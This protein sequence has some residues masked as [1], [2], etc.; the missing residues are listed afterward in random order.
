MTK[1]KTK[2]KALKTI[3]T[4]LLDRS[5]SMEA[6]K[7]DTIGAFNGYLETLRD[8]DVD[9]DFSLLQ[10]DSQSLDRVHIGVPV[11]AV[12]DLTTGTFVPRGTTPLIDAAYKTIKAVEAALDEKEKQQV[13]ICILTDG[14]ENASTQYSWTE[15]Q[16]L[17]KEKTAAGWQF[18]FLGAGID[19]YKQGAMMGIAA[20]NTMSYN[21]AD[22]GSTTSAFT[23]RARATVAYAAGQSTNMSIGGMEKKLAGDA[24]DPQ[25]KKPAAKA[26]MVEDFDLDD[27]TS[28]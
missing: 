19:A 1:P 3:V 6:I 21:A 7:D 26:A 14:Q 25:T 13:V 2:K 16:L 4:F 12:P 11:K 24:F 28:A 17:I 5:G 15:L 22:K 18:N 9:I 10:F 20:A 8:G 27:K 23:T